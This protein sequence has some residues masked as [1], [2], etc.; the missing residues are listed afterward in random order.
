MNQLSEIKTAGRPHAGFRA[1]SLGLIILAIGALIF[2]VL[3]MLFVIEETWKGEEGAHG[4]IVFL[5]RLW[6]LYCRWNEVKDAVRPSSVP[7]VWGLFVVLV[8]LTVFNRITQIVEIEG[9][10]MY[11]ALLTVLY[12]LVGAEFMRKLWFPLFYLAFI[13]PPPETVIATVTVPM[14]IWLSKAAIWFIGLFGYSIGGEDVR[15]YIGQYEFLVAAACARINWIVS[16]SAISLFYIFIRHQAVWRYSL[17]LV[18][19]IV[20]VALLANFFRVLILILLS[21]HAGEAAAQGFLYNF[22][23]LVMFGIA[24]IAI[25]ALDE[26]L[27]P[28]WDRY[29]NN[30]DQAEPAHG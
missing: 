19:L 9:Y 6:L 14:K 16:F 18:L 27:K 25:F 23:G 13:F 1:Q 8:P 21:D 20:P 30:R 24:L 17:L 2:C 10:L 4:P 3:T 11:F 28:I 15:I 26:L 12:C 5:T 7:L 22:A 29:M